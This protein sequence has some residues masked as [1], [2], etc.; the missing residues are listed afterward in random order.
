MREPTT[1]LLCPA[2]Y[3]SCGSENSSR[4]FHTPIPML[5][6]LHVMLEFYTRNYRCTEFMRANGEHSKMEIYGMVAARDT[7]DFARNYIFQCSRENAQAIDQNGGYLRL[8]SPARGINARGCLIEV[9][10][11]AKSNKAGVKDLK[12]IAGDLQAISRF[13]P[14]KLNHVVGLNG[15]ITF[16]T[17]VVPKGVEA[18]IELD[19]ME[20]PAGGFHVRHMCGST[21]LSRVSYTFIDDL[22]RRDVVAFISTIG[23]HGQRFVAAVDL[24][25]TLRVDFM[26]EGRGD[27]G[28]SFAAS[29]HGDEQ[30][31][32]RFN[33]GALVSVQVVWS[34]ILYDTEWENE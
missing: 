12:I 28:L 32:Y 19:F 1:D 11:W 4:C 24:G 30:Q 17:C 15:R 20:V 27:D 26:E 34:T 2:R 22:Y 7:L 9:N 6:F 16:E 8:R 21:V 33:N 25:D 10:L 18:T 14:W 5:Q 31:L 29:K 3:T 13:D 23:K